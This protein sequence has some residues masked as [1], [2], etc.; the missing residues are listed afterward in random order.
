M[1]ISFTKGKFTVGRSGKCFIFTKN[2]YIKKGIRIKDIQTNNPVKT[3]FK[4]PNLIGVKL[5]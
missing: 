4:K 3:T 1:C 2:P 5:K